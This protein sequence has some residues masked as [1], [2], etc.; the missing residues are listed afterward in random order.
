LYALAVELAGSIDPSTK[1]L[2][3]RVEYLRVDLR[4]EY[5]CLLSL[6]TLG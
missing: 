5:L 3:L 1:R 6:W 4:V 2:H